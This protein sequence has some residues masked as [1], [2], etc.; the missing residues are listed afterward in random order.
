MPSAFDENVWTALMQSIRMGRCTPFLGAGASFPAVPLG[1]Q[2]AREWA[3]EYAFPFD[4]PNNLIEVAQFLAV[5]YHALF[6]KDL[7]LQRIDAA[8]PPDFTAR[9]E[10][11]G[12]LA[13][14]PLPVYLTTNYDDFMAQALQRRYRDVRRE[15]CRW[16]ELL[17][18]EPSEFDQGYTPTVANPVVFHLHGHTRPESLVLT[19][20]DY[21]KFLANIARDPALLPQ[22]IQ[23]AL[24]ASTCLFIG[25]RL[26]DW[27]F[28]VLFQ[29][30][31]KLRLRN[32]AV[33]K[34]PDD[35]AKAEKQRAYLEQYYAAID[36]H[37]YWGTAREFCAEL[38]RR[39]EQVNAG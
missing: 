17:Q 3:Q 1:G 11:H 10:P 30:L 9:D 14:L 20:D 28:R 36:L 29:G 37:V 31:P 22:R 32:I 35:A 12:L 16:H 24:A 4:N 21:L 2:I 39:W 6:P 18:D 25:Y 19:E 5:E 23:Q 27:N 26:G 33:L 15:T 34:P 8:Q 7:I 13:E 38:R